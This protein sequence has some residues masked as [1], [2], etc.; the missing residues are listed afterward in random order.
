MFDFV[1]KEQFYR[2]L[3]EKYRI[4]PEDIPTHYGTFHEALVEAYGLGHYKVERQFVRTLHERTKSGFYRQTE[5][6]AR[7]QVKRALGRSGKPDV[8]TQS[9]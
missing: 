7:V 4:K 5:E 2:S 3:E 8:L 1:R 6:I 9:I